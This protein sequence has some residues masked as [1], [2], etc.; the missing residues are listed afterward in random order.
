MEITK[1][2]NC[3]RSGPVS[4]HLGI[5]GIVLRIT[6]PDPDLKIEMEEE[7]GKF[8]L[9]P[10]SSDLFMETRW[11][12][13]SAIRPAGEKTFHAETWQLYRGVDKDV[14]TFTSPVFGPIPY[15]A[16]L[17]R[18]KFTRIEVQL[19]EPYFH[20]RP[21][22]HPLE[23]PLLEILF[24]NYLAS[25]KGALVHACGVVDSEGR[26]H[27]FLGQSGAGK[28]TLT[29]FWQDEPGTLV[30]SDDRIILRWV[31]GTPWMYGTP[32][33]GEAGTSSP[34]RAPLKG[35]YFLKKGQE[36]GLAPM[37]KALALGRLVACSFPPFYDPEGLG[38]TLNFFEKILT[39]VPAYE[40]EFFPSGKVVDLVLANRPL[41][42]P[43]SA[44]TLKI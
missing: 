5:A 43:D 10:T 40:L 6:S 9:P 16:A 17:A 38:F 18:E 28:T 39:A 12:D 2:K 7:N 24:M 41:S 14:F 30:L 36:N 35:I 15:R 34:D 27:L 13:L 33:H 42:T 21:K 1:I 22:V 11:S 25:G 23:Y 29:R 3:P 26:G 31:E 19:H 37:E 32:W 20:G 8:L 44:K 4:W